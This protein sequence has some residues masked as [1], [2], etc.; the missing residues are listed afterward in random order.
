MKVFHSPERCTRNHTHP[1]RDVTVYEPGIHFYIT[2]VKRGISPLKQD[3][4]VMQFIQQKYQT[5]AGLCFLDVR[6]WCSFLFYM[7]LNKISFGF[8]DCFDG[9][10]A[11]NQNKHSEDMTLSSGTLWWT[12]FW[13]SEDYIFNQFI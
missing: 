13:H 6:I 8:L 12:I 11:N 5:F 4:Q 2:T 1:T 7:T 10:S 3:V 9:L